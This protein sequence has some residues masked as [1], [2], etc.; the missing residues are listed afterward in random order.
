MKNIN[1]KDIIKLPNQDNAILD[2]SPAK[3]IWYPSERTLQN[4]FVLFRKEIQIDELPESAKGWIIADSRYILYINGERI[5]W[6]P[7]PSDPRWVEVDPVEISDKLIT[8][9]NVIAVQ[10][11]FFGQGDGTCPIGKPG[12][13]FNLD[14]KFKS[15]K[16][17]K[18]ISDSNWDCMLPPK[19]GSGTL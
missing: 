19:L 13:L 15:G 2:L 9:K 1:Q 6:G 17:E 5:Q 4:T 3:W 14:L 12:L 11:L 7:A 16:T 18:I 8:G 10:V